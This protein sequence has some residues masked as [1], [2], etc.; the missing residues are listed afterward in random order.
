MAVTAT[1]SSWRLFTLRTLCT[2]VG[3]ITAHESAT[4]ESRATVTIVLHLG[5]SLAAA[6]GAGTAVT[7]LLL[8]LVSAGNQEHGST[9]HDAES[10]S[11]NSNTSGSSL[12]LSSLVTLATVTETIVAAKATVVRVAG[13]R[14]STVISV[15]KDVDLVVDDGGQVADNL[16]I[17]VVQE[18]VGCHEIS[19]ETVKHV[20]RVVD[21]GQG[22]N[23]APLRL[24]IHGN[25][26]FDQDTVLAKATSISKTLG[27]VLEKL[28]SRDGVSGKEL[29]VEGEEETDL[30][31]TRTLRNRLVGDGGNVS[32]IR[33]DRQKV[34]LIKRERGLRKDTGGDKLRKTSGLRVGHR[35]AGDSLFGTGLFTSSGCRLNT[36]SCCL[37]GRCGLDVGWV[38]GEE[39]AEKGLDRIQQTTLGCLSSAWGSS[40]LV[41]WRA[42]SG[43]SLVISLRLALLALG[44]LCG[45]SSLFWQRLGL[46]LIRL[47]V[48]S[49]GL[50][51]NREN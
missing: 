15:T 2:V 26:L 46:G 7:Q 22:S 42:H 37:L 48:L 51:R 32:D 11:T 5:R 47:R 16:K 35:S 12:L 3:E 17:V 18:R 13:V 6:N 45:S 50:G 38:N 8:A 36:R 19:L 14:A 9:V 1:R 10:D 41:A 4:H 44:L 39:R 34:S 24:S 29:V 25:N 20:L 40:R 21:L 33:R 49:L 23:V 43:E 27:K 28:G 30:N 31:G